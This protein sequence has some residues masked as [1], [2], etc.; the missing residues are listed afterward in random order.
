VRLPAWCDRIL[1]R[2]RG[3]L[4]PSLYTSPDKGTFCSD[5]RPVLAIFE[6]VARPS[7]R[8]RAM[9]NRRKRERHEL[10]TTQKTQQSSKMLRLLG[11]K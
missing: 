10:E 2:S 3:E 5:H 11:E 4:T 9:L 8:E 1:F 7:E 6:L